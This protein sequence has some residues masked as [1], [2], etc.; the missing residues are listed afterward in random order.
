MLS[1]ISVKDAYKKVLNQSGSRAT[2][3]EDNHCDRRRLALNLLRKL[4]KAIYVNRKTS[5]IIYMA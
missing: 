1:D 5:Q 2:M 3:K 4:V